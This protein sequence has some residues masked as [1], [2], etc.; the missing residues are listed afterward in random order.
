MDVAFDLLSHAHDSLDLSKKSGFEKLFEFKAK[1][2]K[3]QILVRNLPL[4][5]SKFLRPKCKAYQE[6]YKP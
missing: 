3:S 1:V 2:R 5:I 4:D 6:V